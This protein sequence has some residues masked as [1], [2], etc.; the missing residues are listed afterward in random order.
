[1]KT[2][3]SRLLILS[4]IIILLLSSCIKEQKKQIKKLEDN[5]SLLKEENTPI[6]FKIIE[7]TNDS[8]SLLV[9]FYNA[10]K[11]EINSFKQTLSGQ[12]LSIDFYMVPV[13]NRFV[14][15]P[16][17]IFTDRVPADEGISLYEYYNEDGYPAIFYTKNMDTDLYNGLKD[18]YQKVKT[19]QVDSLSDHFGNMV[20]DIQKV[21]SF[22][23]ENV[24]SIVTHTKGGIEIIEE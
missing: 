5:I 6:R 13:K 19:G 10:D 11:K 21:K 20:H 23:S 12:E 16:S 14:A 1:M 22:L 2:S 4:G 18:I 7:K 15:F 17:K 3:I 9:K 8:I 24:Y